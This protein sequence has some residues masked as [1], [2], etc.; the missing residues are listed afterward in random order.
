MDT[1]SPASGACVFSAQNNEIKTKTNSEDLMWGSAVRIHCSESVKHFK[2][3]S[4][5]LHV[6]DLTQINHTELVSV[7]TQTHTHTHVA[8]PVKCCVQ[9]YSSF[10]TVECMTLRLIFPGTKQRDK[11]LVPLTSLA[12]IY[13]SLLSLTY[14]STLHTM[15][16]APPPLSHCLWFLLRLTTSTVTHTLNTFV[17]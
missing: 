15:S 16:S 2:T 13:V 8:V 5:Y 4:I 9:R 7:Q 10:M 1:F 12:W 3:E 17:V 11:T 14:S 6:C